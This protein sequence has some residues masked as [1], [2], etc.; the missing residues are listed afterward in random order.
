MGVPLPMGVARRTDSWREW[1]LRTTEPPG[2]PD[3]G[4]SIHRTGLPPSC[5]GRPQWLLGLYSVLKWEGRKVLDTGEI[6]ALLLV[7]AGLA[8]PASWYR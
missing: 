5:L 8:R 6:L 3:F 4:P 2:P 1:C 7:T